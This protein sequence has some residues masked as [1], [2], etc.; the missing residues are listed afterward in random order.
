MQGV[1]GIKRMNVN[2]GFGMK[3]IGMFRSALSESFGPENVTGTFRYPL[4]ILLAYEKE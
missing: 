3:G 4:D 1:G 2:R